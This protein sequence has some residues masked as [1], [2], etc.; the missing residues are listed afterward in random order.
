MSRW[1]VVAVNLGKRMGFNHSATFVPCA[2]CATSNFCNRYSRC[3]N[4]DMIPMDVATLPRPKYPPSLQYFLVP[5]HASPY[6]LRRP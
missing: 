4:M 2:Q 1:S 5:S 6:L 3:M